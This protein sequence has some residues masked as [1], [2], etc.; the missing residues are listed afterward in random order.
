MTIGGGITIGGQINISPDGAAVSFT[1]PQIMGRFSIEDSDVTSTTIDIVVQPYTVAVLIS[2]CET[3]D[4]GAAYI[5]Q[6]TSPG[7]SWIYRVRYDD[8]DDSR[9]QTSEIWYAINNTGSTISNTITVDYLQ[10]IDDCTLSVTTWTGCNLTT[11]WTSQ[12]PYTS[13]YFDPVTGLAEATIIIPESNTVSIIA[14]GSSSATPA[15]M[16]PLVDGWQA[17]DQIYNGGA[18]NWEYTNSSYQAFTSPVTTTIVELQAQAGD[19]IGLS[20]GF[21]GLS[22]IA[23]ALVGVPSSNNG[24][25]WGVIRYSDMPPPVVAG[26]QTE[27]ST[28][29]I[30]NPIGFTINNPSNIFPSNGG[31][32]VAAGG[33]SL[34]NIAFFGDPQ[35]NWLTPVTTVT[36]YFGPGSSVAS[37]DAS[38]TI[39][40]QTGDPGTITF[41]TDPTNVSYPLTLNYPFTFVH[42][43]DDNNYC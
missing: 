36:I 29:T 12:T 38:L 16:A 22:V 33:L 39:N 26:S 19:P 5:D 24:G 2:G 41:F 21:S 25:G 43:Q 27:D 30:N 31:T 28:A 11:P 9:G 15:G 7:L 8:P 3:D 40:D 34:N 42:S 37:C 1:T 14:A 13:N 32:G 23:D 4:N 18:T 35:N 6:V 17:V 20:G 10:Q